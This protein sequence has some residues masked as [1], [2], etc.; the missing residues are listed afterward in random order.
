MII[1]K[2]Q[3]LS[4][5]YDQILIHKSSPQIVANTYL[6]MLKA[7]PDTIKKYNLSRFSLIYLPLCSFMLAI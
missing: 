3:K 2:Y 4:K 5:V 7:H 1:K 6:H